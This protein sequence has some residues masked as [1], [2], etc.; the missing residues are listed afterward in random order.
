MR[1]FLMA[2]VA[3]TMFLFAIS[4]AP[5]SEEESNNGSNNEVI[6]NVVH[7]AEPENGGLETFGSG[8]CLDPQGTT[9]AIY[10]SPEG[11]EET[12]NGMCTP[13]GCVPMAGDVEVAMLGLELDDSIDPQMDCRGNCAPMGSQICGY[14]ELNGEAYP[15]RWICLA[16]IN[17]DGLCHLKA[18]PNPCAEGEQCTNAGIYPNFGLCEVPPT[19]DVDGDCDDENVCTSDTCV[20]G[21]C[22]HEVLGGQTCDDG[23]ACTNGDTCNGFGDC[24]SG[25]GLVCDDGNECTED[26]C[27]PTS[28]CVN[29]NVADDT[30]CDDG[31]ACTSDDVCLSGVCEGLVLE[32]DDFNECTEDSCDPTSGCINQP[33]PNDGIVCDDGDLCTDA[34]SCV[35][36][37]CEGAM[38]NCD[39]SN[40]C[41][42]DS[43]DA[44]TGD[45]LNVF[46]ADGDACTGGVCVDGTCEPNGAWCYDQTTEC[47]TISGGTSY[48][49]C[50]LADGSSYGV[51]GLLEDC[52]LI[53]GPLACI[54]GEGCKNPVACQSDSSCN[55][56]N[57]CT[58]DSCIEGVCLNE[59]MVCP[60]GEQC[61]EGTCET[62][63]DCVVDGDCYGWEACTDGVCVSTSAVCSDATVEKQGNCINLGDMEIAL[64]L[65]PNGDIATELGKFELLTQGCQDCFDLGTIVI[66][67]Y[68]IC[69]EVTQECQDCLMGFYTSELIACTGKLACMPE[70]VVE[71]T[72]NIDC[73]GGDPCTFGVCTDGTCGTSPKPNGYPCV[74]GG[75]PCDGIDTCQAGECVTGAPLDCGDGVC[76]PISGACVDCLVDADCPDGEVCNADGLC[77]I[78]SGDCLPF[79]VVLPTGTTVTK[80]WFWPASGSDFL[81]VV[82]TNADGGSFDSPVGACS[83]TVEYPGR[84]SSWTAG[85]FPQGAPAGTCEL[86]GTNPVNF[87]ELA[88]GEAALG[89]T[90]DGTCAP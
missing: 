88:E 54:D 38:V 10:V 60:A 30:V 58:V 67:C 57:L 75:N 48:W 72:S 55:D 42:A 34:D 46:L 28:G 52:G 39:D 23:D 2:I 36:G 8:T 82:S 76:D 87:C 71:C 73:D 1:N 80:I 50:L 84:W 9:L 56:N 32:C 14:A 12:C 53:G 3:C 68:D 62:I 31:D 69:D 20:N 70:P 5:V 25:P 81:E 66:A 78:P 15:G 21:Q 11:L 63:P 4:C 77:V 86:T 19:C 27:D 85:T 24:I 83:A 7:D 44:M 64:S 37:V 18:V 89:C 49:N 61:V 90:Y 6:G 35:D 43:C 47:R 41:T 74:N 22:A 26:S 79:T 65:N 13:E 17:G 59:A 29:V 16:W 51:W 45:C 40:E 33:V